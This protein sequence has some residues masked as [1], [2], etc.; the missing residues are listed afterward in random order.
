MIANTSRVRQAVMVAIVPMVVVGTLRAPAMSEVGRAE[1]SVC[2]FYVER[3]CCACGRDV[4]GKY[5]HPGA[6]F[7]LFWC[8]N[9]TLPGD[10]KECEGSLCITP[11]PE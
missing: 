2:N 5:C 9:S 10:E 1:S 11:K 3:S 7:G 6:K 8:D 4:W